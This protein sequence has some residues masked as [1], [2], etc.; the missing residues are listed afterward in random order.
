M[1]QTLLIAPGQ[2]LEVLSDEPAVLVVRSRWSGSPRRPP[3][4]LHPA[5]DERFEV[6]DGV[7]QT[8]VAGRPRTL[9][10]GDVLEV[11][12]GTVHRMWAEGDIVARW[13]TR[14]A[15]RTL[16]LF[17]ALDRA[18]RAGRAQRKPPPLPTLAAVLRDF[19]DTFRL[20]GPRPL[21]RTA[22]A[23]LGA[24]GAKRG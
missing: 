19:D 13:E 24:L 6:L 1:A 20:A 14:P 17:E 22:V 7:L 8:E 12:R 11:E 16:A 10:A 18:Q 3:A 15:G 23:A 21:M 4:H 9:E 2:A 5:Q